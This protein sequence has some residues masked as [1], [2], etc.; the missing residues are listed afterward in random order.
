MVVSEC[1][2]M[3][4]RNFVLRTNE[5]LYELY[6]P[7]MSKATIRRKANKKRTLY[8]QGKIVLPKE[9]YPY[10]P[11]QEPKRIAERRARSLGKVAGNKTVQIEVPIEH[12]AHHHKLE[13]ALKEGPVSKA[14]FTSG[15]HEGYIKNADNEI[16]YTKPLEAHQV[17]FQV[18]F[19]NEPKW[20][21]VNR[22]ESV[23]LVK[24]EKARN[25]EGVEK[26]FIFSDI[27]IPFH[28]KEA[29]QVALDV[30]R[31]V[32][33]DR[34]VFIGDLLDLSAWSKYEQQPEWATA[35][36]DAIIEAH[37]LLATVRKLLPSADIQVIEANHELRMPKT[38][39][40][41]AMAAYG[42]R[43]ADQP[44]GFPVM[45]VP[46]L[47]AFDTL[48]VKWVPGYPANRVYLAPELQIIHGTT[49]G[50]GNAGRTARSQKTST[51]YGHDHRLA[52]DVETINTY[53][54]GEQ[55]FSYGVGCLCRIDGHVPSVKSGRK[56]DGTPVR[57][58]E[59]WSQGF[60]IATYIPDGG[61][62]HV[63]QIAINTLHDYQTMFRGKIY[64]S[65]R[66]E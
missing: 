6:G 37:Q 52:M 50:K 18:E 15:S 16:E 8:K 65:Q 34:V 22:V 56:L 1:I 42:L 31:D 39:L 28:D 19:D 11:E 53:D 45:S 20:V 62:F 5:E 12:E 61:P 25:P 57:N 36:Q 40:R 10:D 24:G 49:S 35:T 55:I 33:P 44:E 51:I 47:C 58:L 32:K 9:E 63:E 7:Y 13:E 29:L 60:L 59:N 46:Y 23:K 14:T 3:D 17:R 21:P 43:R 4:L 30:L 41:N 38:L 48:D 27:Q 54:G 64:G 66:S 2:G 26:A